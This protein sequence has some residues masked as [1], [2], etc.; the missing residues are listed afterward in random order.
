MAEIDNYAALIRMRVHDPDDDSDHRAELR[1]DMQDLLGRLPDQVAAG[2]LERGDVAAALGFAWGE[3]GDWAQAVEWLD[4]ALTARTGN[5][6]VKAV[7]ECANFRVR[8]SAQRWQAMRSQPDDAT[9]RTARRALIADIERAIRELDLISLRAPTSDRLALLGS[10]CQRLAWLQEAD[11][12]RI[13]ALVNMANYYRQAHEQDRQHARATQAHAD[14]SPFS[15]WVVAKALSELFDPRQDKDWRNGLA[16][17]CRQMM[18][19][20]EQHNQDD[21][22]FKDAIGVAHCDLALLLIKPGS[23]QKAAD[24][25][26]TRI[27]GRYRNAAQRGASPRQYD[28]VREHVEFV[29]ALVEA[30]RGEPRLRSA[31]AALCAAL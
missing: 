21:P 29:Q 19:D 13:E 26:A 11:A 18:A 30:G 31:L 7:E 2:W 1:R 3:A 25:A 6:P 9:A 16:D 27:A 4:K 12:P 17:A 22:S 28:S 23:T 14:P 8:L 15:Q 24:A 10:A 5:C 20:A